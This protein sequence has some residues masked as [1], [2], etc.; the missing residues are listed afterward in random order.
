MFED[1]ILLGYDSVS[2]GKLRKNCGLA[3]TAYIDY[4]GSKLFRNVRHYSS[5]DKAS[6]STELNFSSTDVKMHVSLR[7]VF[8]LHAH[9]A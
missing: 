7:T 5:I 8:F 2:I 1:W 9:D 4:E 6:C 3:W